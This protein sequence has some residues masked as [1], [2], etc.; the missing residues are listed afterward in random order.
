MEEAVQPVAVPVDDEVSGAS[1][2]GEAPACSN[3]ELK[4]AESN[5]N[6]RT[7]LP[8]GG[9]EQVEHVDNLVINTASG[10][11][12][13]S[14]NVGDNE[15]KATLPAESGEKATTAIHKENEEEQPKAQTG[16]TNLT[17]FINITLYVYF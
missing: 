10:T 2:A 1:A 15:N 12:S 3:V 9:V 17:L 7:T 14:L 5:A 4:T 16:T 8:T 13:S 11:A 6:T